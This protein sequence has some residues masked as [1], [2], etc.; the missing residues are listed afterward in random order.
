MIAEPLPLPPLPAP[1]WRHQWRESVR[2]PRQ[3]L[4]LLGLDAVAARISDAAA[5]QF[6]LRVPRAFVARM[7]HGDAA[8]PL[9]RQV[10]PLDEED[11]IVPGFG[12]DAV[13]DT[14]AR[15]AHGVLQKYRGRALLVATGSCAVHCRYCFRRHFDYTAETAAAGGW[16]GAIARIAED[17]GIEEVLLSGGD[18]LSLATPK[19]AELTDALAAIP[20]VRRLRLHTR[21]PI[22]LPDRVD[23]RLA[24]L[25]GHDRAARQ[26]CAGVRRLGGCGPR[27]PA[28]RRRDA[29][30]PGGAA[31]RGQRQPRR[32]GRPQR[33]RPC[34]RRAAVLPAPARPRAGR[35]ALRSGRRDRPRLASCAGRTPVRVPRAAP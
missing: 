8:D 24:A 5:A 16:A 18:P 27:P 32:I 31:A 4:A 33:A 25:A 28:R 12:F 14:A 30:Q 3:L 34:G 22:V 21:L 11:R 7:R 9:L 10:L 17:P 6:P 23:D 26:P 1:D 19:L 15:T 13:G 2:D 35:G 20:H 29:A